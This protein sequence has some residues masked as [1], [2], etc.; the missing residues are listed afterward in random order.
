MPTPP[1]QIPSSYVASAAAAFSDVDGSAV[2]VSASNP[3]PVAFGAPGAAPLA[4]T[5]SSTGVVGPYA[6]ALGRAVIL[7]L[8]G[9]WSGTVRVL[10]SADGGTTKLPLTVAGQPWGQFTGNC[11]EAVW[12]ESEATA[13]LYL[14]VS[15]ASG[16]LSYRFAQ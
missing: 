6:P 11:C 9:S 10:R 4:G 3:L 1:I 12:E 7:T 2:V 5:A 15:L 8:S 16:T 14:D 13:R